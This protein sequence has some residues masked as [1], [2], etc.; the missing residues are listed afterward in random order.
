MRGR[1][2]AAEESAVACGDRGRLARAFARHVA[3]RREIIETAR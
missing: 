1:R 3:S 2:T